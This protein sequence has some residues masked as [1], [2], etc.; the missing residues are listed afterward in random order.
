MMWLGRSPCWCSRISVEPD[1]EGHKIMMV[2]C[3]RRWA[4]E[5]D[6]AVC[7]AKVLTELRLKLNGCH[8]GKITSLSKS[9][10]Q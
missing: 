3:V 8:E 2:L 5:E 10:E 9:W 4:T 1:E 6:V 7:R